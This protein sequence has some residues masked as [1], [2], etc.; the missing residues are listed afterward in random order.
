MAAARTPLPPARSSARL[1]SRCW[2]SLVDWVAPQQAYPAK[3]WTAKRKVGG[4]GGGERSGG[5]RR[6]GGLGACYSMSSGGF[7]GSS[8]RDDDEM[9]IGD[10]TGGVFEGGSGGHSSSGSDSSSVVTSIGTS[11]SGSTASGG[12]GGEEGSG[13]SE[14]A[15]LYTG[16]GGRRRLPDGPRRRRSG[17]AGAA[18]AR[19]LTWRTRARTSA[20]AW[21][22]AS[23]GTAPRRPLASSWSGSGGL[24]ATMRALL[25]GPPQ[26]RQI[27]LTRRVLGAA[28]GAWGGSR[29]CPGCTCRVSPLR[30]RLREGAGTA[31]GTA[32]A[33]G[34][35]ALRGPPLQPHALRAARGAGGVRG[36]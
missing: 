11:P 7:R 32:A 13:Y 10:L 33:G 14:G 34:G 27:S 31:R 25:R 29:W 4:G 9:H 20:W 15:A 36:R 6:R 16:D 22:R 2:S 19:S 3:A 17:R 5:W 30:L 1:R 35:R 8:V 28:S 21:P 26:A 12:S 18:A 24:T 23:R